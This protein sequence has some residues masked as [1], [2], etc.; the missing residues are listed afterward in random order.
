M[1]YLSILLVILFLSAC[2]GDENETRLSIEEHIE[3]NNLETQVTASGL[4]YIINEPGGNSRPSLSSDITIDYTGYFLGGNNFDQGNNV[5]F[6]LQN[7]IL[8][9]QEGI[10]LIGVGGSITLLVPSELAYGASGQGSIPGNTDLG[11]EVSLHS[12]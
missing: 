3:A 12:F 10:R 5:T 2:G 9:W 4:H 7:L 1:K 8:G 6:T 11:F